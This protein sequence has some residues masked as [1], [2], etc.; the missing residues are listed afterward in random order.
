[1]GDSFEKQVSH[2]LVINVQCGLLRAGA[3]PR[4]VRASGWSVLQAGVLAWSRSLW[5]P[6]SG[7][8]GAWGAAAS[9]VL[10]E[11]LGLGLGLEASLGVSL[12][13]RFEDRDSILVFMFLLLFLHLGTLRAG[14]DPWHAVKF[15]RLIHLRSSRTH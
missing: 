1:M 11:H 15:Y 9:P 12:S 10:P 13:C 2:Q 7:S 14:H 3:G 6:T 5:L 8:G 4:L